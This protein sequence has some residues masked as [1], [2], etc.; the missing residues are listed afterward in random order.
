MAQPKPFCRIVQRCQHAAVLVVAIVLAGCE[1]KALVDDN[2]V[3]TAAPP[4][5]SLTNSSSIARAQDE[6]GSSDIQAVSFAAAKGAPLT[7]NSVVA[8]VNGTPIFVDD[9]IGSLRIAIE[10]DKG[11]T[12][13]QRQ[14][15]LHS[16]V[17]G[18]VDSFV[19]QEIVLQA[20]NQAVPADRQ[21]LIN[22]SLEKPFQEVIDNIK[23]DRKLETNKQLDEVLAGEGL[24]VDLLRESFIRIQ[25]VQGYLATLA[26]TPDTI[27]RVEMVDYY[28]EHEDDFTND[29]RI[30]WQEIA[31][32]FSSHGG[33]QGAE[34][35]MTKV[36]TELQ[37]GADFA[38]TAVKYSDALSAEK[39]GDMGWLERGGLADKELE[40]RLF[41]MKTGQM[42]R[43]LIRDDRFELFRVTDHEHASTTPFGD[44]QRE[45]EQKILQERQGTAREKVLKD[46]KAKATVVTMFD[47]ERKGSLTTTPT[48][49]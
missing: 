3:F 4:R 19:E 29:E 7:G 6:A 14:Q 21:K 26:S 42:T 32:V 40:K 39:R 28:K 41:E 25:K 5:E 2:P 48:Q 33:R 38:E 34:E 11:I 49:K 16:Q 31:V 13:D 30:R 17:R 10:S 47:D 43:V 27:D 44:V 12:A 22:E 23:R 9:L 35:I 36:V 15:I 24:S 1:G 37:S 20:L 8:E 45:I 18:R 46:L